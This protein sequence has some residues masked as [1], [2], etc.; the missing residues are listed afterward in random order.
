MKKIII[1]M[2][3]ILGIVFIGWLLKDITIQDV[4]AKKE[5]FVTIDN[6]G[7]FFIVYDTETKV[8]YALSWG[9]NNHGTVTL[10]VDE[11][12]KPLLYKGE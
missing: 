1:S 2:L 5:R 9:N 8:E 4:C 11:T 10:L 12:G 3:I 7:Y 6:E